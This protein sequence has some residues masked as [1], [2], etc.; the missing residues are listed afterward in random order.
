MNRL[1]EEDEEESQETEL[2][3]LQGEMAPESGNGTMSGTIHRIGKVSS[4]SSIDSI[5]VDQMEAYVSDCTSDDLD[6][7][8]MC[9][10]EVSSENPDGRKPSL[11]SDI[12]QAQLALWTLIF[13]IFYS[14]AWQQHRKKFLFSLFFVVP[15]VIL[16]CCTISSLL[17][18]IVILGRIFST[19]LRFQD[20]FKFGKADEDEV[21]TNLG[22]TYGGSGSLRRRRS[23]SGNS[24][25]SSASNRSSSC[26]ELPKPTCRKHS[27]SYYT[28]STMSLVCGTPTSPPSGNGFVNGFTTSH[29]GYSGSYNGLH[30]HNG[31][32]YNRSVSVSGNTA[33]PKFLDHNAVQG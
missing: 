8:S 4:V 11:F 3:N 30:S 16:V 15:P 33:R 25:H 29:N 17:T 23:M 22:S 6:K 31:L 21:R 28:G 10:S 19:P 18:T 26:E 5:E 20:M 9:L 27:T 1:D 32:N 7:L 12:V 2:S 13:S 24:C 14:Y